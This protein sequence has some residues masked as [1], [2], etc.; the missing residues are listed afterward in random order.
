[1]YITYCATHVGLIHTICNVYKV[2]V[3]APIYTDQLIL[4]RHLYICNFKVIRIFL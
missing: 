3:I 1:M 2:Y 4:Q